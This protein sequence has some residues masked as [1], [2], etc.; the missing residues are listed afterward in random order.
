MDETYDVDSYVN[1]GIERAE[2]TPDSGPDCCDGCG[3]YFADRYDEDGFE[4]GDE[5]DLSDCDH[6]PDHCGCTPCLYS[7]VG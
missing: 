5:D 4:T 6:C 1:A 3:C 7:K 2:A